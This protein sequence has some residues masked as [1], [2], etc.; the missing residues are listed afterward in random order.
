MQGAVDAAIRE[1]EI[2]AA[3][4]RLLLGSLAQVDRATNDA[5]VLI[6]CFGEKAVYTGKR[7]C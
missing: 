6:I 5:G 1:E 3:R 2:P 4:S 7:L